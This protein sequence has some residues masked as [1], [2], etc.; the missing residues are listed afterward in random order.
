MLF[1]EWLAPPPRTSWL[2]VGCGTGAFTRLVCERC[3]PTA[4]VAIDPAA[5]QIAYARRRLPKDTVAFHVGVA[6]ALPSRHAS[7]DIVVSALAINFMAD[8]LGAVREMRRVV[9]V[10][11]IIAGYVWDFAAERTPHTPLVRALQNLNIHVPPPPGGSECT[12]GALQSLFARAE[13]A[14]IETTALD[15]NVNFPDFGAFW[16]AQTPSFSPTTRLIARLE[17]AQR[18]RLRDLLQSELPVHPGGSI[19]YR[20]RANAV[21]ARAM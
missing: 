3:Q 21:K 10:G 14:E 8:R 4:I 13:L 9:R 12:V 2:E 20:A 18:M 11:G 5:T 1:L 17:E 19:T 16:S 6:E 15:I 7:Y